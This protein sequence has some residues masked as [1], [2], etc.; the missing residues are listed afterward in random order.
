MKKTYFSLLGILFSILCFSQDLSI[1]HLNPPNEISSSYINSLGE[2]TIIY[3]AEPNNFNGEVILFTH[4]YTS[5]SGTFLLNNSMYSKAYQ[6]GYK[7]AF[8]STTRGDGMWENGAILAEAISV[9]KRHY[10]QKMYIVAHSNGG[11][12]SEVALF[13]HNK[14]RFVKKVISLGTP[15]FGTPIADLSQQWWF[16]WLWQTTGLNEGAAT[17]TTYYC[18]EVVRPYMDNLASNRAAKF[19]SLGTWG[20]NHGNGL[21]AVAA[22]SSGVL[23]LANNAGDNDGI[24]PYSS[25]IRPGASVILE[26]DGSS[27]GHF[28]HFDLS[29]GDHSW[30]RFILPNLN[31]SSN[32]RIHQSESTETKPYTV[33]SDYQISASENSYESILLDQGKSTG[34]ITIITAGKDKKI[35]FPKSKAITLSEQENTQRFHLTNNSSV[36]KLS[37]KGKG[38]YVAILKQTGGPIA[39]YTHEKTQNKL[40]INMEQ[41][42]K[43]WGKDI[44]VR[45]II[46]KTNNLQGAT[47]NENSIAVKFTKGKRND[48]YLDTQQYKKGIY[49]IYITIEN[50]KYFRRN[51]VSGFSIGSLEIENKPENTF[52]HQEKPNANVSHNPIQ[53]N[54]TITV[55]NKENILRV[56]IYNVMGLQVLSKEFSKAESSI[57]TNTIFQGL[58][59]GWYFITIETDS[60][61][62]NIKVRK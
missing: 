38:K 10:N 21:S 12:A 62:Y 9:I 37:L 42:E 31:T 35:T 40:R 15:F 34:E 61:K 50:P 2:Q 6:A 20:W 36:R 27:A 29:E 8:V 47:L 14:K 3:G 41:L 54:S 26:N 13:H 53:E 56:E 16:N 4:G 43:N 48:Y 17:S 33:R 51:I 59:E 19:K 46:N 22:F 25:A 28:D 5:T 7:T 52:I 32:S 18:Q 49:T 55:P 23:L 58:P 45:A 60:I 11:K 1:A 39:I 30:E 24:T 44:Q 57:S